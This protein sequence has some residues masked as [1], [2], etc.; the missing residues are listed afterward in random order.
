LGGQDHGSM[1]GDAASMRRRAAH[2]SSES[3][4]ARSCAGTSSL[5]GA[6]GGSCAPWSAS[7]GGA[8]G[9]VGAAGA[10]GALRPD[11]CGTTD[12]FL[13]SSV[14][15][16]WTS[17]CGG[18]RCAWTGAAPDAM[19]GNS[20]ATCRTHGVAGMPRGC[21]SFC[22]FARAS[23]I[24]L[25]AANM[26]S[27]EGSPTS[28]APG[29]AGCLVLARVVD[30]TALPSLTVENALCAPAK[31]AAARAATSHD[32]LRGAATSLGGCEGGA[33]SKSVGICSR[34]ATSKLSRPSSHSL[35]MTAGPVARALAAS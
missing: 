29:A 24:V 22:L 9:C 2:A 33:D 18:Q 10:T 4:A 30:C 28:E 27:S 8:R 25:M 5:A 1:A 23:S 21:S 11:G 6:A 20:S 15:G 26:S 35:P 16:L 32:P 34:C 31:S 3:A 13:G 19:A 12:A 14:A 7:A 17:V